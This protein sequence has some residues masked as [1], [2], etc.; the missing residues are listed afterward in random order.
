MT[1]FNLP[2]P[3]VL[4]SGEWLDVTAG[5]HDAIQQVGTNSQIDVGVHGTGLTMSGFCGAQTELSAKVDGGGWTVLTPAALD[6]WSTV[7]VFT[8]LADTMHRVTIRNTNVHPGFYLDKN[9]AFQV[10][11]SAPGLSKPTDMGTIVSLLDPAFSAK[12]HWEGGLLSTSAG[13][14]TDPP[15]LSS[16]FPD[17]MIQFRAACSEIRLWTCHNGAK[18]RVMKNGADIGNAVP[19]AKDNEWKWLTV[20]EGLDAGPEADYAVYQ[21]D[22]SCHQVYV[23][24]IMLMSGILAD[25]TFA[26]R[27]GLAFYGDS[28]LRANAPGDSMIG[29]AHKLGLALNTSVWNCSKAGTAVHSL[30]AG[31]D[32]GEIRTSEVTSIS[33]APKWCIVLYGVVDMLN[34]GITLAQFSSSYHNMMAQLTTALPAARV[35][36]LG[37]LPNSSTSEMVRAQWS[38]A[39]QAEVSS[40][41]RP[42]VTFHSTDGWLDPAADT[43]DGLHPNAAG[44][45]RLTTHLLPLFAAPTVLRRRKA[46][47]RRADGRFCNC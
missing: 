17:A 14:Y 25:K 19:D 18:W 46:L 5:G 30:A 41:A 32:A 23:H 31:D 10:T 37:I 27:N 36:C 2:D 34:G 15:C 22:G 24:Q 39:I 13:G 45:D 26:V 3:G 38:G 6:A 16:L 7:P 47:L 40:I 8:G 9:P 12:I 4:F 44:Y 42:L 11:G 35:F 33:P 1:N 43:L 28:I 21:C 20:A 29:V